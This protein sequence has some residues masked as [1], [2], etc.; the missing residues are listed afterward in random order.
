[1]TRDVSHLCK[2]PL[3]LRCHIGTF[4]LQLAQLNPHLLRMV[5][6]LKA[7]LL[8]NVMTQ[9]LMRRILKVLQQ[10]VFQSQ[11]RTP[12][13]ILHFSDSGLLYLVASHV[14]THVHNHRFTP[15]V[16]LSNIQA[17]IRS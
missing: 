8:S 1:M 17:S 12:T 16:V 14:V 5:K 7:K 9:L 3:L 2:D 13:H 11:L 10:K 15:L 6:G 4:P